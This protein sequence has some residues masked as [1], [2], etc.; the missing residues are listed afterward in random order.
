VDARNSDAG[1]LV[2][3]QRARRS[4]QD[5]GRTAVAAPRSAHEEG[6]WLSACS[7]WCDRRREF[8]CRTG[9]APSSLVLSRPHRPVTIA[10]ADREQAEHLVGGLSAPLGL[11][12]RQGQ[13]HYI[14]GGCRFVIGLND[15]VS[16]HCHRS[17]ATRLFLGR[18]T[19][20]CCGTR[21][22]TYGAIVRSQGLRLEPATATAL[23]LVAM[24][25]FLLWLPPCFAAVAPLA[26]ARG[27]PALAVVWLL[28]LPFRLLGITSGC[29][30][31]RP[32]LRVRDP[33][34]S[35]RPRPRRPP[36][37]RVA[38]QAAY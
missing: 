36:S 25:K 29:K 10:V 4:L 26:L 8:S 35:R 17:P 7:R 6:G 15:G 9:P 12:W 2:G 20:S 21:R 27:C 22:R 5:A 18:E 33:C 1:R 19:P 3:W 34:T 24:L 13:L 37:S 23:T 11:T 28:L 32:L 38:S 14:V 16:R 30:N 31:V